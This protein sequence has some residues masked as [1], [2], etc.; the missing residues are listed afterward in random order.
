MPFLSVTEHYSIP[1][2]FC[3]YFVTFIDHFIIILRSNVNIFILMLFAD[4]D[5]IISTLTHFTSGY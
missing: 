3:Q 2:S 5:F 1:I 4:I